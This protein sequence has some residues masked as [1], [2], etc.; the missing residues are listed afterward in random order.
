MHELTFYPISNGEACLIKLANGKNIAF[1]YA[2]LHD[3]NDPNDKR[4]PL[5]TA[6]REDIGWYRQPGR[7][8]VD[9][10]AITHGDLDHIKKTS[11]HFW[12][13]PKMLTRVKPALHS[14]QVE[15]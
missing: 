5:K 1:D 2:D 10:L 8:Y 7:N 15:V 11:E 4:L 6:F 9:V 13:M 3:P 14:V 12:L